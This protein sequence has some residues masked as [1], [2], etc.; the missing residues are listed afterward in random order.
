VRGRHGRWNR[1]ARTETRTLSWLLSYESYSSSL[2][3]GYDMGKEEGA[4]M[5][6]T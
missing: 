3:R 5:K 4:R 1:R 2:R 6:W